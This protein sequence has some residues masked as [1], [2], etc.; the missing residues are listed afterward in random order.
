VIYPAIE[1]YRHRGANKIGASFPVLNVS[2]PTIFL[3]FVW[4]G[5]KFVERPVNYVFHKPA[6]SCLIRVGF[7]LKPET[8]FRRI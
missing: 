1:I 4:R 5:R 2:G 7:R 6:N 8:S 3:D